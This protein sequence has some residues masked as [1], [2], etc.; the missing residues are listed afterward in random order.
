MSGKDTHYF[1]DEDEDGDEDEEEKEKEEEKDED[2]MT[3]TFVGLPDKQNTECT[4]GF[5]LPV[6]SE[7]EKKKKMY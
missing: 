5:F 3:V 6:L 4:E 7:K 2:L 1:V